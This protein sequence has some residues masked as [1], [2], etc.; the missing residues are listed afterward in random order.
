M[1][2][3]CSTS[4]RWKKLEK[5][6]TNEQ[7]WGDWCKRHLVF[8]GGG[9]VFLRGEGPYPA[10]L[11]VY[12]WQDSRNNMWCQKLKTCTEVPLPYYLSG[13]RD[14]LKSFQHN[15]VP[16]F[17]ERK[18]VQFKIQVKACSVGWERC[19][20]WEKEL[21]WAKDQEERWFLEFIIER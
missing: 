10:I 18:R 21:G 9:T 14:I 19:L 16:G 7:R 5:C 1:E 8:C 3:F 4:L 15:L 20:G 17:G 11:R 6:S 12:S 2:M 13:L